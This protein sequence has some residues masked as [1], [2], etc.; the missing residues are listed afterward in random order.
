MYFSPELRTASVIPRW[1][2][3]WTLTRDVVSN[4]SFFVTNYAYQIAQIIDWRGPLADL[5]LYCLL[6]DVD[7]TI[8]GDLVAPAKK[9]ILDTVKAKSYID[10]KM[11]ERLPWEKMQLQSISEGPF[12]DD[13][14]KI[15]KV[16]DRLDAVIFLVVEQRLGNSVIAPRIPE[17]KDGLWDAWMKLPLGPLFFAEKVDINEDVLKRLWETMIEPAI[18]KHQTTGGYG[19]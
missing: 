17:A 11:V 4:H 16:A 2:V 3:V 7:E 12:A 10:R 18:F 5:M 9:E 15:A 1:S 19:L 14:R 13:I 6:H 8:T